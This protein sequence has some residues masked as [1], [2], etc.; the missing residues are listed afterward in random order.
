MHTTLLAT[1]LL[2]IGPQEARSH[3]DVPYA[4]RAGSDPA[5]TSLDV[6]TTTDAEARP[7]LVMIHG[8]GWAAGDKASASMVEPKVSHFV[9]AGFVYFSVNY[10]LSTSSSVQHPAHVQDIASALAFVHEHAAE[11]GGDPDQLFVMGHSSGAHLA[12]L[13][14]L[15]GRRL[16]AEGLAPADLKGTICLDTKAYDL[17]RLIDE[18]GV[19]PRSRQMYES[20]FGRDRDAW[21][22][23]SPTRHVAEGAETP[24]FLILHS[25]ERAD[26][27][28]VASELV[29]ALRGVE[30]PAAAFNAPD[31][32]HAG[33][34][35]C[36]G[37]A[38]DPYTALVMEFLA[39]PSGVEA[40]RLGAADA[41]TSSEQDARPTPAETVKTT[42]PAYDPLRVEADVL[43]EPVELVAHDSARERGLPLLAYLPVAGEPAPVLLFSHGLGGSR[44]GSAFLGRHWAARGYVAV[45]LQHP[46]SDEPIWRNAPPRK[47]REAMERAASGANFTLRVEDVGFVLDQLATWSRAEEHPLFERLDL[48]H[49]GMSGHSF[50]AVT[51]QAVS[52]QRFGALGAFATDAR[53][54]AALPMSPSPPKRGDTEESFGDVEVP[55]LL[56]TGT[57]DDSAIGGQTAASRREVYPAL[58]LE[59]ARYE[60]VLDGAEHSAFTERRLPGDKA[61]RDPDHH[62]RILALS[63]AFWDGYL[64]GDAAALAWLHG[65]GA[66]AVLAAADV[67]RFALPAG[68]DEPPR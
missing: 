1:A 46:G 58:S 38:D 45:F 16:A 51:T 60:L 61:A 7:V 27:K 13:V 23:A 43:P 64:R 47:R 40:L 25:G 3:L 17:P 4:V 63:T 44:H 37:V 33:I 22:D 42:R 32:D 68:A 65:D 57:L 18:L 6:Y 5:L 59:C 53:I 50:G 41:G 24:P 54:D 12:A 14:S 29:S 30:V 28:L 56:M 67:W 8:G 55:W 11:Y 36:I 20:A 9:G 34:N 19:S 26:G 15:D 2:A 10:R 31:R 35:A 39:N 21:R 48:E 66:R 62:R 52:G 49:V